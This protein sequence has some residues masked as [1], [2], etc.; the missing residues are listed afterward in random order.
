M[1]LE[2]LSQ[3]DIGPMTVLMEEEEEAWRR[4]LDWDFAPIRRI[5]L[6]FLKRRMLPGFVL[7]TGRKAIGYSYFLVAQRKGVIGAV[8]ASPPN[9]QETADR[10]LSQAITSLKEI[11][12]LGRIESQI[13]PL[14]G[15]DATAIFLRHGFHSYLRHYLELDLAHW[16][17]AEADSEPIIPWQSNQLALAAGV[18]CLSYRNGIDQLICEDYGTEANCEIYLRS[19]VENPGC[20]VFLPDSSFMSLNRHGEPSG[21]ILTSYI[22]PSAAMIPQIAIH[23][24]YQGRGL[25]SA[26]IRRSLHRLRAA[27]YSTVRL[28]V[29]GKNRRAAEWYRRLGFKNRRDFGA[30]VWLREASL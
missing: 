30:Y 20:G 7:R 15:L 6:S 3:A 24:A 16:D 27:G 12:N 8:Y 14:H 17:D 23:P 1:K 9:P 5:L 13:L 4:E 28:T 22:S 29:T 10:I 25:G 26:L 18:A 21:F 2:P 19:L 11:H